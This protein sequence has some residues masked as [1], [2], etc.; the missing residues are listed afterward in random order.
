M[1]YQQEV[2]TIRLYQGWHTVA[3]IPLGFAG[4]ALQK[5]IQEEEVEHGTF[6]PALLEASVEADARSGAMRGD[7]AHRGTAA[8]GLEELDEFLRDPHVAQEESQCP[9][10][11]CVESLGDI[12]G[13]DMILLLPPLQSALGQRHRSRRC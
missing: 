6:R 7:D 13:E 3:G 4:K 2:I 9:M 12:K 5:G 10:R 1:R 11:G 8:K